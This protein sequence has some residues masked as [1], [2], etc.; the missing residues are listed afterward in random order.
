MELKNSYFYKGALIYQGNDLVLETFYPWFADSYPARKKWE[1]TTILGPFR[2]AK[3]AEA[4]V[5]KAP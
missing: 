5:D 3:E 1:P 2:T 4:S